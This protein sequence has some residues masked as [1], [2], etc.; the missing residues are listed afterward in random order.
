[1]R[2]SALCYLLPKWLYLGW[3]LAVC[4]AAAASS[5]TAH[6]TGRSL[7]QDAMPPSA[8]D[9]P[10][11]LP[12][13][14]KPN[15][16]FD[17]NSTAE[18]PAGAAAGPTADRSPFKLRYYDD[19]AAWPSPQQRS[20]VMEQL[21]PALATFLARSIRVRDPTGPLELVGVLD[22]TGEPIPDLDANDTAST[23]S[24]AGIDGDFVMKVVALEAAR[25]QGKSSLAVPALFDSLSR[26]PIYGVAFICNVRPEAFHANLEDVLHEMMHTLV[27]I[28]ELYAVFPGYDNPYD[29]V[30]LTN[31]TGEGTQLQV[32][33]QQVLATARRH[34][35]C[36][37]L[38]GA[39]L[40]DSRGGGLHWEERQFGG[41]LMASL[42]L[43]AEAGSAQRVVLTDLTLSLLQDS[44]WYDVKYGSAGFNSF[45]YNAGCEFAMGPAEAVADA[46]AAQPYLCTASQARSLQCMHD[47]SAI[48]VCDTRSLWD[49]LLRVSY[50]ATPRSECHSN[51]TAPGQRCLAEASSN[52]RLC[53]DMSCSAEGTVLIDGVPCDPE[54]VRCPDAERMC[55]DPGH[56]T[57]RDT[58]NDC[59][60]RGTCLRGHCFC[61]AGWGGDD[62]S[63]PICLTQCDDGSPCPA[64]G[65]C[66]VPECGVWS[67]GSTDRGVPCNE[68][69]LAPLPALGLNPA[70][71]PAAAAPLSAFG[72]GLGAADPDPAPDTD[73][74]DFGVTL[75][76]RDSSA[77]PPAA[78]GDPS[79]PASE[80]GE[81]L[82]VDGEADSATEIPSSAARSAWLQSRT[83]LLAAA[84]AVAVSVLR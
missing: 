28:P 81:D 72:A 27:M 55:G 25:C 52:V 53:V 83:G 24:G 9:S 67:S 31:T 59:S 78:L 21:M 84:V 2:Q 22:E 80:D 19:P 14:L 38:R 3:W 42:R 30:I 34:L 4:T 47:A 17:V 79:A 43:P 36:S 63:L 37:V 73:T 26:R 10:S 75:S 39:P 41:E 8:D 60:G 62:C 23:A 56:L 44:N 48:G 77:D 11:P 45:G 65:F 15:E 16:L 61:H 76:T 1:M 82:E 13:R 18:V 58:L 51:G 68:G 29:D 74:P 40:E 6:A 35:A 46:A 49:G 57:C 54:E 70:P 20:Y 64:S 5:A 71:T 12:I 50:A 66:G 69:A 32:R 7:L 33:S